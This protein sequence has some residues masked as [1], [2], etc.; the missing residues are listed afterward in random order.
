MYLGF[1]AV[2]FNQMSS[3]FLCP[4]MYVEFSDSV[5]PLL[6]TYSG[7]YEI[8]Q[9][10]LRFFSEATRI[11]DGR[12]NYIESRGS[13]ATQKGHFGYCA[14]LT[15]W[16][17]SNHLSRDDPCKNYLIISSQTRSFSLL[18]SSNKLWYTPNGIPL[19]DVR[20]TC[21][22]IARQTETES[23][24]LRLQRECPRVGILGSTN[25]AGI[26]SAPRGGI[27]AAN[28]FLGDNGG[29][30]ERPRATTFSMLE[31][32][33]YNE[34]DSEDGTTSV[35]TSYGRPIYWGENVG[36]GNHDS[37]TIDLLIFTGKRWAWTDSLS[38]PDLRSDPLNL[39]LIG[40]SF[41]SGDDFHA[42]SLPRAPNSI[43]YVSD[44]VTLSDPLSPLSTF[45]FHS[46]YLDPATISSSVT[47]SV[48][49]EA[50]VKWW[51][52][53][54]PDLTRPIGASF[55]CTRCNDEDSR[56]MHGGSCDVP[57]G[58]CKCNNGATGALCEIPPL[59]NGHCDTYFNTK[60]Y[61]YDGGDCCAATCV[62]H[63]CKQ[64]LP[65][66]FGDTNSELDLHGYPNCTD[67][68]MRSLSIDLSSGNSFGS[69]VS[70]V[71][72]GVQL[73]KLG[74]S[75]DFVKVIDSE[76]VQ[77]EDSTKN[78]QL[79]FED[80]FRWDVP[81]I[82]IRYHVGSKLEYDVLS[83][84]IPQDN[85]V[86][87]H[88]TPSIRFDFSLISGC[89]LQDLVD[90]VDLNVLSDGDSP[91]ARGIQWLDTFVED[92]SVCGDSMLEQQYAM[93]VLSESGWFE[94]SRHCEWPIVHCN[95]DGSV[96]RISDVYAFYCESFGAFYS[97]L[98]VMVVH[99]KLTPSFP[100]S[101]SEW[102]CKHQRQQ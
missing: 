33:S 72:D 86:W 57:S 34:N 28:G 71:C 70:L 67:P 88:D 17:F 25:D 51:W 39:T 42:S 11:S 16:T 87:Y 50:D 52:F 35:V 56:C 95:D 44:A 78:C 75:Y 24:E 91:Q 32:T 54:S 23:P 92:G 89:L 7:N 30:N 74:A 101:A 13:E 31:R 46:Y 68:T 12:R 79:A 61:N 49:D 97:L 27:N 63:E 82:E 100:I 69:R 77:V 36:S 14:E 22:T 40:E 3:N 5:I 84:E 18:D 15:R 6:G 2:V 99:K 98:A 48:D 45:W 21:L 47:T 10:P 90:I 41:S 29:E 19:E 37:D 76:T 94:T 62:G 65:S 60:R 38:F 53:P 55:T 59:S 4:T 20:F 85:P 102:E 26:N 43:A 93:S 1:A 83:I 96:K 81:L 9:E 58:E 64:P 73:L 80:I 66:I 8:D